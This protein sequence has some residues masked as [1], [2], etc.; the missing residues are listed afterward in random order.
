M[1]D[2][3]FSGNA[4][5]ANGGALSLGDGSIATISGTAFDT[6]SA[7]GRGGAVDVDSGAVA[8][9]SSTFTSNNVNSDGGGLNNSGGRV[10]VTSS[11]FSDNAAGFG[12]AVNTSGGT[13][14]LNNT[15]I[16]A[17]RG[18]VGVV[19]NCGTT[20]IRS[21]RV[22]SNTAD[23]GAGV[24]QICGLLTVTDST[25]AYN[26]SGDQGGAVYVERGMLRMSGSTVAHNS[27]TS[28]GGGFY[29]FSGAVELD[30]STV[31]HNSSAAGGAFYV[32]GGV[33]LAPEI[34]RVPPEVSITNSTLAENTASSGG[35]LSINMG[36][37]DPESGDRISPPGIV[38]LFSSIVANSGGDCE[39]ELTT[40]SNSLSADPTCAT[41]YSGV[42]LLAELGANGGATETMALLPGS[43]AVDVGGANCGPLDQRG[44]RRPAGIECDLG[45]FELGAGA[46]HQL[47][48][49][50]AGTGAG[51]VTSAPAGID[52]G[53]TCGA[54]FEHGSVIT[55]TATPALGS[56]FSGWVGACGGTPSGPCVVTLNAAQSVSAIF[57]LSGATPTASPTPTATVGTPTATVG[58]S[59]ATVGTPTATVGTP[60]VIPALRTVYLPMIV[61]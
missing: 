19:H 37:F 8:I 22:L 46:D 41:E 24:S 33:G 61:R 12:A 59:T 34:E 1:R 14:V 40:T 18:W 5:H 27:A 54:S 16:S 28:R 43:P 31:A 13:T 35:G 21:S 32:E 7:N 23:Y 47:T 15:L 57:T 42:P 26:A 55:L 9:E 3:G 49:A 17:N 48:V 11:T 4:A 6:N 2:S 58:T 38:H 29:V 56:S 30:T 52:C 60:T 36:D 53:V 20:E 45:A 51:R 50:T 44:Y 39:G 10:S 25:L